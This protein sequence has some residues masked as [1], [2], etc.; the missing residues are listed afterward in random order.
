MATSH[1]LGGLP[2]DEKSGSATIGTGNVDVDDPTKY[3]VM[4]R[5]NDLGAGVYIVHGNIE[6]MPAASGTTARE[7]VISIGIES[8]KVKYGYTRIRETN[9]SKASLEHT[10]LIRLEGAETVTLYGASSVV[11]GSACPFKLS[12][13][14]LA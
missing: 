6:F 2:F 11:A 12:A 7:I 1:V 14:K 10:A 3:K 8:N 9:N 4:G 13:V 5:F